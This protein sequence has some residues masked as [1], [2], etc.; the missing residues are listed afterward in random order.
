MTEWL[1]WYAPSFDINNQL[2]MIEI[3]RL[4]SDFPWEPEF[5][6]LRRRE[7]PFCFFF[8]SLHGHNNE[9]VR[10]TPFAPDHCCDLEIVKI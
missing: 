7:I 6:S 8:A 5:E 2:L 10:F 1:T 3:D 4:L 9:L